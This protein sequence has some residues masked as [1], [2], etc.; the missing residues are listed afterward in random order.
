MLW[1]MGTT[2]MPSGRGVYFYRHAT[3]SKTS[4]WLSSIATRR[5]VDDATDHIPTAARRRKVHGSNAKIRFQSFFMLMMFQP[6][7]F[8]S[9]YSAG[10]KVPTLVLPRP[11]AGP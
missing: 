11:C 5:S 1:G 9:S 6:F 8:A 2:P 10:V 4:L 3:L 7:L